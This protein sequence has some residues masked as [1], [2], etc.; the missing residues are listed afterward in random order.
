MATIEPA[1]YA[2]VSLPTLIPLYELTPITPPIALLAFDNVEF[3][4]MFDIAPSPAINTLNITS[5]SIGSALFLV[6]FKVL[7]L[8]VCSL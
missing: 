1:T 7:S 8:A 3:I 5:L 2:L 4:V 6:E